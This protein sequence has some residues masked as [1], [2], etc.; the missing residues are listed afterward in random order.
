MPRVLTV[1]RTTN[2]ITV[3]LRELRKGAVGVLGTS[4][5][6]SSAVFT[7]SLA[8]A[9]CVVVAVVAAAVRAGRFLR[10][11]GR[12]GAAVSLGAFPEALGR[13]PSRS[14][15]TLSA[16]V[17]KRTMGRSRRNRAE[18]VIGTDR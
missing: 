7:V 2:G 18:K 15:S 13:A 3:S 16:T 6:S 14:A 11:L 17:P 12:C 4:S 9:R 8:A 5:S 10:P 1:G